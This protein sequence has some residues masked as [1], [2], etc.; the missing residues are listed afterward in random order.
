VL[1]DVLWVEGLWRGVSYLCPRAALRSVRGG[2]LHGG[3]GGRQAS[4][5]PPVN[6]HLTQPA[7]QDQHVSAL[8]VRDGARIDRAGCLRN[9]E[10]R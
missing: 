6:D 8:A 3:S 2:A 7:L 5:A 9:F 10:W 4:P 1:V